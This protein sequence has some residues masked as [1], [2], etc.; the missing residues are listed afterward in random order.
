MTD[1]ENRQ[2]VKANCIVEWAVMVLKHHDMGT[3]G[4]LGKDLLDAIKI[5]AA[6]V[7]NSHWIST[8]E[9]APGP[10]DADDA[11]RVRAINAWIDDEED[12]QVCNT[13]VTIGWDV[14]R[15]H[16][17]RYVAWHALLKMPAE[18]VLPGVE[19]GRSE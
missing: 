11:G 6:D 2:K 8:Q 18:P 19:R 9:R 4:M 7:S 15:K 3:S 1:E 5:L 14:V 13:L 16:P 17:E 12:T 10:Q